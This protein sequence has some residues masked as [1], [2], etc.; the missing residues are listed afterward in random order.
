MKAGVDVWNC[1]KTYGEFKVL[2]DNLKKKHHVRDLPKLPGKQMFFTQAQLYTQR[3]SLL[4]EFLSYIQYSSIIK[5]DIVQEFLDV[6]NT[7]RISFKEIWDVLD[8]PILEGELEKQGYNV[9]NW[10]MRHVQCCADYTM[11]YYDPARWLQGHD[12]KLAMQKGVVDLRNIVCLREQTK[13][14]QKPFILEI[15]TKERIWKF[16]CKD[17]KELDAWF[18]AVQMLRKDE[19]GLQEWLPLLSDKDGSRTRSLN[20]SM[21]D[22]EDE[23]IKQDLEEIKKAQDERGVAKREI[24]IIQEKMD[25][26]TTNQKRRIATLE[27]SKKELENQRRILRVRKEKIENIQK[28]KIRIRKEGKEKEQELT[29]LT[30]GLMEQY[31]EMKIENKEFQRMLDKNGLITVNRAND[32]DVFIY[33]GFRDLDPAPIVEGRLWKFGKAGRQKPKK[34]FVVFVA[35]SHGCYIEWSEGVKANQAIKRMKLIG[36]SLDNNLMDSRKLK[37]EELNRLF[38]LRGFDRIAIFLAESIVERNRWIDG[39][40]R[41]KLPQLSGKQ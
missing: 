6:P 37:D 38:I 15:T 11:R 10:K 13:D 3:K 19:A 30:M 28:T 4:Q 14:P 32:V 34:K 17:R 39:F 2:R 40:Q 41:A 35:L 25:D 23:E 12:E 18:S 33:N 26:E 36:W 24:Q 22:S 16:S 5:F 7:L 31:Q 21:V 20:L 1:I 9:K 27:K 8:Y 29:K